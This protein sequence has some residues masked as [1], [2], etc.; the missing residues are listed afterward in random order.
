MTNDLIVLFDEKLPDI[1][2]QA[3]HVIDAI[4]VLDSLMK[5]QRREGLEDAFNHLKKCSRALEKEI[6]TVACKVW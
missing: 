4:K 3:F 6:E 5:K 1:K 2:E